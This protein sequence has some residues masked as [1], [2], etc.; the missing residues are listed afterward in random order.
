[1]RGSLDS[2]ASQNTVIAENTTDLEASDA[3]LCADLETVLAGKAQKPL[4]LTSFSSFCKK[5]ICEENLLFVLYIR[6]NLKASQSA[7]DY[8]K[9]ITYTIE[10]FISDSADHALNLSDPD[11]KLILKTYAS[12]IAEAK[13]SSK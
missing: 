11:R 12:K 7:A 2:M 4:D 5:K 10:H 6:D 3:E 1:M 9:H 8:E 13:V